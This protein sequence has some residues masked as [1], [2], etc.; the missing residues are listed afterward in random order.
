AAAAGE[1]ILIESGSD[2]RYPVLQKHGPDFPTGGAAALPLQLHGRI[3]GGMGLRF[4]T[5]RKFNAEDRDFFLT[6]GRECAQ[7]LE[8]ARLYDEVT[9]HNR[10]LEEMFNALPAYVAMYSGPDHVLEFSNPENT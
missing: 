4:P 2:R 1:P 3:L 9:A 6:I 5:G 7:A 10:R 8:R